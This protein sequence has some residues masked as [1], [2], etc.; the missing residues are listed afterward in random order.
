MSLTAKVCVLSMDEM[1][2]KSRPFYECSKDKVI[3]LEDFGDETRS[4][5]WQHLQ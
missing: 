5:N 4:V 3:G 1:S 2:L